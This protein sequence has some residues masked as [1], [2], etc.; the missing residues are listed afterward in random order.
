MLYL[1]A[2]LVGTLIYY[3]ATQPSA[4]PAV[5][6]KVYYGI[7][8]VLG[9]YMLGSFVLMLYAMF[10]V[11]FPK[12]GGQSKFNPLEA[13]GASKNLIALFLLINILGFIIPTLM[14]PVNKIYEVVV[15]LPAYLFFSPSYI[16]VLLAYSFARI[17][18]LSWGT[19]GCNAEDTK[20]IIV[21]SDQN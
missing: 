12:D 11:F 15:A 16:H 3:S 19:K 9:M 5:N 7:S 13:I 21:G 20:Q 2:T 6:K 10:D 8:T 1:Y 17:D 18:D 4:M 14:N